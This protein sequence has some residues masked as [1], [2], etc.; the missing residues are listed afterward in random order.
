[1]RRLSRIS[2]VV[3]V[4]S[5]LHLSAAESRR[6]PGDDREPVRRVLRIVKAI[7]GVATHTDGLTPPVPAPRP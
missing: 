4:L 6:R 2:I 7:F 1:M 3:V 5:T